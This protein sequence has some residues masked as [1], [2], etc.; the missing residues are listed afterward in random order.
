MQSLNTTA[1]NSGLIFGAAAG[2]PTLNDPKLNALYLQHCGM[3]T[4]DVALKWNTIRKASF[5]K[6]DWT[7]GDAL[8]NWATANN[9]Q[10]KGH[11][12]AWN[13]SNPTWLWRDNTTAPAYGALVAPVTIAQAQGYFEQHI[14]E[15]VTR[16]KG[17][18]RWW[19]VV[20]E[21]I[22]PA[23]GRADGMRSK[24]WM[25]VFGPSYVEI[26]LRLAHA[27]DPDARLFINEANLERTSLEK[28]RV[29]FLA[30]I[31]KLLARG[32][33]LHGIGFESHLIM[34]AGT[35]HEGVMWLLSEIEK[36]GLEVHISE[37]DVA[38][39]GS[40]GQALPATTTDAATI[41]NA[42][43]LYVR[44]YLAD[45]LS[46]KNVKAITTWQ[47]TDNT[48]WQFQN[49]KR[50]L[51]FDAAYQPKPFAFEIERAMIDRHV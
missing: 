13:E 46:F 11:N 37:L 35:T 1:L 9:I 14:T 15:T 40:S 4:T 34:W 7:Q 39:L 26:A 10:I 16:Y 48:S 41:D 27:A 2:Q 43:A 5:D 50:P 28:N 6:P 17:K 30:L 12:L 33:P 42:V 51:P 22:E 47:M 23:N 25:T 36:R 49:Q 21:P 18:I 29:F 19:D 32:V 31:D 3:I 8:V 20:N 38:P 44:P 45:V 24:L